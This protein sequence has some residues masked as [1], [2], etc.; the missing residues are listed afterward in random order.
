[1]KSLSLNILLIILFF[2]LVV[3]IVFF[4]FTIK[5]KS[6]L[7]GDN[8]ETNKPWYEFKSW[9]DLNKNKAAKMQY[10]T[11]RAAVIN[12]PNLDWSNVLAVMLPKLKENKEYIGIV[13][14]EKD[15][16]TLK[17]LEYE[18]SPI[19]I[20]DH[21]SETT[22]ASIPSELVIKYESKP[23]LIIFHTHPSD[24]RGSPLPSSHDLS[25]A[26]YLGAKSK[27]AASAVISRYGVLMYG[28]DWP[29]Y[30]AINN[31]KN[32][33]LAA[34]NYGHDVVAAHEAIRSW[35]H[36]TLDDYLKFYPRHRL[37]IFSYPSPEMVGDMRK[38]TYLGKLESPIDHSL[39]NSRSDDIA[40]LKSK[41]QKKT[42]YDNI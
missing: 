24:I 18:A 39:I 35:S 30:K 14:L 36:H 25:T 37:F 20:G 8:N 40:R 34:L 31:A 4:L 33:K 19:K 1:M 11:D 28:I 32:W 38:D 22:F 3:I 7:G 16:K 23:G 15:G 5:K 41:S 42:S 26:I 13:N 12:N 21:F 9:D 2:L 29:V 10:F 27:F 6:V 17:L